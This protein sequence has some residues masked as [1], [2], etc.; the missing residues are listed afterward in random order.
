MM[1]E[2]EDDPIVEEPP[3]ERDDGL[4]FAGKVRPMASYSLALV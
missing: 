1:D 3:S 4:R 2:L